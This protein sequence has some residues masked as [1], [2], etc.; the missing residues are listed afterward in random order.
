[1]GGRRSHA[2]AAVA[3]GPCRNLQSNVSCPRALPRYERLTVRGASLQ[4]SPVPLRDRCR[5][6]TAVAV[7]RIPS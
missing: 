4:P 6:A 1:M 3:T 7:R 2:S 5:C